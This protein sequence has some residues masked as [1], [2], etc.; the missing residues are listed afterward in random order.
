MN[1]KV[2]LRCIQVKACYRF[3]PSYHKS[4]GLSRMYDAK[5]GRE[6]AH[7]VLLKGSVKAAIM[8]GG[9]KNFEIW[10]SKNGKKSI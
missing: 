4:I 1:S 7:I 3:S 9:E 6:V 8:V 5:Y 2:N 10:H